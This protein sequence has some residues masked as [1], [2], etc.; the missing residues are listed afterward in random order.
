VLGRYLPE[1]LYERPKQGFSVP[2][3]EWLRGP[4]RDWAEDL[5]DER[6]LREDGLLDVR[7]IRAR[8]EEHVSGRRA[9]PDHLWDVLMFQS[10]LRLEKGDGA[11]ADSA[12]APLAAPAPALTV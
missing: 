11:C 2:V 7:S 8:W 3:G 9:W 5:L 4:L 12:V 10:W 6:Q 1:S